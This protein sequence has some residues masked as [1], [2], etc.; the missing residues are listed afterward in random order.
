MFGG[1]DFKFN[2][3]QKETTKDIIDGLGQDIKRSGKRIIVIIDDLD[4]L[5]LEDV[6][7]ML[8]IVRNVFNVSGMSFVL[9]YDSETVNSFEFDHK[10]VHHYSYIKDDK[11]KNSKENQDRESGYSQESHE[12]NN[13]AINA[14]FEKM[15]QVKKT[16]MP[17]REKLQ[18]YFV[19][20]LNSLVDKETR[21]NFK[22][23]I[24]KFIE[25]AK[26]FFSKDRFPQYE[27]YLGD[28]RKVKRVL[29]V[30]RERGIL[31]HEFEK[32]DPNPEQIIQFI[33]LYTYH[34]SVFREVYIKEASGVGGKYFSIPY[35]FTD[36]SD[37]NKKTSNYFKKYIQRLGKK[38]S[39]LLV[40][41]FDVESGE[42]EKIVKDQKGDRI[43]ETSSP[44]FNGP[45]PYEKNLKEYLDL[46]ID[47]KEL[48]KWTQHKYHLSNVKKLKSKEV[49]EILNDEQYPLLTGEGPRDVFF[50]AA[51]KA[52]LLDFNIA[53]KLTEYILENI[54]SYSMVDGFLEVY[55]GRRSSLV[56]EI[57]FLLDKKGWKDENNE[58]YNNSDKNVAQIA[59]RIFGEVEYE[60]I[61]IF[62]RLMDPTRGVLGL[63]DASIFLL[64]C[65]RK[66]G[67]CFN[68]E[69]A[70]EQYGGDDKTAAIRKLSQR[71]FAEFK[72]QY[73]ETEKNFLEDIKNLNEAEL[74][75]D[76][77]EPIR[78]A[79]EEKGQDIDEELKRIRV[80]L[81]GHLIWQLAS[82]DQEAAGNIKVEEAANAL[83]ISDETRKYL[84]KTCFAVDSESGD[85]IGNAKRFVDYLLAGF[86]HSFENRKRDNYW[87]PVW[88]KYVSI[89]GEDKLS[90]YWKSYG[91]K[92]KEYCQNLPNDNKVYTYNYVAI[93]RED[94]EQLFTELDKNLPIIVNQKP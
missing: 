70:L 39:F 26:D 2:G 47:K 8:S 92:V 78:K 34:P 62:E 58:T 66:G 31:D 15:V 13:Q 7:D 84:F 74:L 88:K 45:Y 17:K 20:M 6:K 33:L 93:Y 44:I 40:E 85:D 24:D 48:E 30:I 43:F 63:N 89:L 28:I 25:Q 82:I 5:Y 87:S 16:L 68:L 29:N 64:S 49:S 90:E 11:N 18:N 32:I 77:I 72:S 50:A 65:K 71:L 27:C 76:F 86:E 69:R 22:A 1:F 80:S 51:R 35:S 91:E 73:I 53:M 46:I 56:Y 60:G 37:K 41:L 67:G 54:A 19:A 55:Q 3:F 79:F 14:Y 61:G 4:R 59:D 52:D 21:E 81:A 10:T 12:P 75:G 57:I 94:L 9:C 36:D 42:F 83:T 38:N 23:D